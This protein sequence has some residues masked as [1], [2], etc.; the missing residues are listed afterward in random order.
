MKIKERNKNFHKDVTVVDS[1]KE[2]INATDDDKNPFIIGGGEIYKIAL[3][4]ADKIELTKVHHTFEGD[5]Y[6]EK[7]NGK[8]WK[9]IYEEKIE[10]NINHK[11]SFSYL[12]YIKI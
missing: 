2:A 3:N 1:F 4:F 8:K 7:I 5:T 9:K 10:Q 6:F 11:Y 12:T